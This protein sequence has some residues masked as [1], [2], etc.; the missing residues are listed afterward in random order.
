M[1]LISWNCCGVGNAATVRELREIAKNFPPTVLCI[2]ETQIN[3]ERVEVLAGTLGYDNGYTVSSKDRGGG[4][5]V[6]WN[7]PINIEILGYS[8]YHIDCSVHDPGFDPWRMALIY[9]E[10][11][12]HLRHQTRDIMKGISTF[13][14]LPWLCIGAFNEILHPD[15]QAGIGER[16]NAQIQGFHDAVDIC[17]LM[18][19]GS[20]GRF[21]TY[22]KRSRAAAI[23][24]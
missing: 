3:K 20:Q 17:M 7:N 2:L 5:E 8:V 13:S 11:Q 1:S 23:L 14:D 6:L 19:I 22:E 16:G 21:W 15:E 24:E 9:G 18:D 12:T 10:A 4:L